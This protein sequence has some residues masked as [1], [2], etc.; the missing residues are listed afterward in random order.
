MAEVKYTKEHEVILV[1]GNTITVGITD[2]AK[3]ALGDLV[4]IQLPQAGQKIAKGKDFA[5][6]ESVKIAS[7]IYSP[8]AGEI[9]EVNTA[10]NDNVDLLKQGLDKGGWIAK[11]KV[12][13][14]AEISELLT[15]SQ[16]QDYLK[17]LA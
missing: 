14:A 11:I 13:N 10:M 7:E 9:V 16:Y 4:F 17:S 6:V 2:F 3:D 5:V 8:M 1:D 15:E 12:D